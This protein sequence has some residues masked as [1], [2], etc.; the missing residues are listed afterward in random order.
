MQTVYD[1]V[2]V[3]VFAGLIVLFLQRSAAEKPSDRLITYV[4]PSV[5]C[6][7]A[8]YVGNHGYTWVFAFLIIAVL[9]YIWFALKPLAR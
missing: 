2:S 6:A 1:W 5:G 8:N 7:L 9:A 4:P 3:A